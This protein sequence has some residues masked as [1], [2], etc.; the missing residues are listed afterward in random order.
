M[1]G[2]LQLLTTLETSQKSDVTLK[3]TTRD[4]KI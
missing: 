2:Y 3:A 4:V 1:W